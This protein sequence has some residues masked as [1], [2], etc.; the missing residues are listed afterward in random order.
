MNQEEAIARAIKE[1]RD[2]LRKTGKVTSISG[3]KVFVTVG[4]SSMKLP[5]LASYTPTVGDAVIIDSAQPGSW[6]VLGKPDV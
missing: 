5:R 2:S 1:L 3:K 6:I 4:G